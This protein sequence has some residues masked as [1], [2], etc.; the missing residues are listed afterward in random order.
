MFV[1]ISFSTLQILN[2]WKDA[3][4]GSIDEHER[5][6]RVSQLSAIASTDGSHVD[7]QVV[8]NMSVCSPRTKI[9]K[10]H[11]PGKLKL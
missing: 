4:L 3:L 5:M 10:A 11:T 7:S 1:V 8:P 9:P 6:R 2:V